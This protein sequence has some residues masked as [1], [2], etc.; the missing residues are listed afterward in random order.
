[1]KLFILLSPLYSFQ[2]YEY[3]F[4]SRVIVVVEQTVNHEIK[5][6]TAEGPIQAD[7]IRIRSN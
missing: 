6:K 5:R 7:L 1:M 4:L 2:L 3:F